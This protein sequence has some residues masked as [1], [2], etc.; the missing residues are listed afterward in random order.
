MGAGGAGLLLAATFLAGC[1]AAGADDGVVRMTGQ[2]RF[3]P[4]TI[5]VPVGGTVTWHND[6]TYAHTVT[7]V[8]ESREP[9]GAFD[10]GEVSG[11]G[12]FAHTFD[13]PGEYVY[14]CMLHGRQEMIGLVVVGP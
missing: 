1:T 9:T 11:T 7:S 3:V 8:T 14:Q 4:T 12:R 13:E 5:E 2:L 6:G 10:S